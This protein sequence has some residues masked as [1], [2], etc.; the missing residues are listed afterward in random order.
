MA[1]ARGDRLLYLT[2]AILAVLALLWL[3]AA[4]LTVFEHE[5]HSETARRQQ[6]DLKRIPSLRGPILDRAGSP[7]AFSVDGSSLAVDPAHLS[8]PDTLAMTLDSLGIL[9]ASRVHELIE[10][11]DQKRFVWLTRRIVSETTARMLERRFY[12]AMIRRSE[13]KRLYPLGIAAASLVGATGVD[14]AGLVGVEARYE[15]ALHGVDGRMLD[16]CSGSRIKHKGPGRVVLSAPQIG[17]TVELTI[18]ARFQEIVDAHLSEAMHEQQ[19]RGGTAILLE[20][21]TGEI[22]A[23]SSMPAFH[24][25]SLRTADSLALRNWAVSE[26]FEP[27]ST[28]KLVAFAAAI[29]SGVVTPDDWIDCHN[30]TRK[31]PGGVIHDH[32]AHE[33]LR[34]WEVFVHSSNIGTGLIA[35]MLGEEGF[36]RMERLLGFGVSTGVEIPGEERGRI[37]N[38]SHWSK[39]SLVTQ[40]FG[41]EVSCTALQL[42]AAYG[43]VANGGLLLRPFLVRSVRGPDGAVMEKNET[44]IIRR[45]MH[46]ETA[47]TMRE[48]MRLTVT[49]GTGKNAEVESLSPGGKTGTAQKY[50]R[51]ENMYSNERYIASFAGFAPYDS[52]RWLCIVVLDEP[53]SSIW[54]GSVAAPVFSRIMNDIAQLEMRATESP[55]QMLRGKAPEIEPTIRVPRCEGLSPG[56]ARK[57]LKQEGLL[58]RLEG[59]GEWVAHTVPSSGS[60]VARGDVVALHLTDEADSLAHPPGLPDFTGLSLRDAVNRTRWYDI[61]VD[62]DGFGWVID[63]SPAPGTPLDSVALLHLELSADSCRAFVEYLAVQR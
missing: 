48:M 4:Q 3:R 56:L 55:E 40:A 10:R 41:Q 15:H 53:R 13:P 9:E 60:E 29:D 52:P 39:R 31:V 59:R 47:R 12:P 43:A 11:Y 22:L 21:H 46:P 26:N 49:E 50:I 54:G 8:S 28:Y 57:L 2:C 58:P 38:P 5:K 63:Q 37:P 19:A 16:F 51:E 25:E 45:A 20:P 44:E 18:D 42:A 17:S 33:M 30:G 35:E 61:E 32:E 23:L 62:L 27:G 34:V 6:T 7:L 24:P 14:G 1:R 36:Y